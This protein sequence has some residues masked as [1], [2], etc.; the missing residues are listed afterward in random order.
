MYEGGIAVP[1]CA[2]WPG[3]IKPGSRSDLV[4]LTSDL[5]PTFCEAAGATIEHEIDGVSILPTLLGKKQYSDRTLFWVRREGGQLYQGQDYYAVRRGPWKLLQNTPFENYQ[6]F[7][8][9]NDP[10]ES[11]DVSNKH[12]PIVRELTEALRRHVQE[13]AQVPWQ[14]STSDEDSRG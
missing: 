5:F 3:H 11:T 4:A 14:Q 8:L 12:R 10:L 2:V 6:L 7:N 1:F 9:I 13:A